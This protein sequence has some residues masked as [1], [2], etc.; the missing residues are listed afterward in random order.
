[1]S[2][3]ISRP[4]AA[5]ALV[6]VLALGA[7]AGAVV[8]TAWGHAGPGG[9]A[10]ASVSPSVSPSAS[11]SAPDDATE[12]DGRA[13]NVILLIGDGMGDA[14][15]AVARSYAYG[16]TGTFPSL[17]A[18]PFTG[19]YATYALNPD[20]GLPVYVTDSAA[21]ASAWATGV[22]T[23]L[24]AIAVDL[25]GRPQPTLLELAQDAGLRTGDVTASAIQ[26]ATPAVLFAHVAHRS[27]WAP[28]STT[29]GCPEDALQNGGAG[30][31]TEQL[32]Q[33]RP[34]VTLGGGALSFGETAVAGDWAGSTLLDQ[35]VERGYQVVSDAAGLAAVQ[36]ADASAPVLGLF[37]DGDLP[38]RWVGPPATPTGGS[39]PAVACAANPARPD[40]VPTLAEM[41]SAAIGLLDTGGQAGFLLQVEGAGIDKQAHAANP[42]GQIGETVDL[43][44]AV[45]V[46]LAFAEADGNTLVIVTADHGQ[47]SQLVPTGATTPGL[48]RTLLT[49]D[50]VAMTVA[51]GTAPEGVSQS[52]TGGPVRVVAYGPGAAGVVGLADSTALFRTVRDALGLEGGG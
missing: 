15:L 38:P 34:D 4:M 36:N 5:V 33:A 48:T 19:Q 41:T 23:Y 50:G 30:S 1:M 16:A 45:A 21:S 39:E 42:C 28:S 20:D 18:L 9:P 11:S 31:I 24:G 3:R 22:R 17:D 37:A 52:H 8:A 49:A 14:E 27:C 26:D 40:T 51:Y 13:R 7:G 32:L 47:S 10:T 44:E 2:E 29:T 6:G 46:A 43:D 12:Q 25:D 35:A